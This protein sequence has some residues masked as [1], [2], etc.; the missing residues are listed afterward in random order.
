MGFLKFTTVAVYTLYCYQVCVYIY[1]GLYRTGTII[2]NPTSTPSIR[3]AVS[4]TP[5]PLFQSTVVLKPLQWP[6]KPRN[7]LHML[8]ECINFC[9]FVCLFVFCSPFC[10]RDQ[11]GGQEGL[12]RLQKPIM[13]LS[14]NY[15][16]LFCDGFAMSDQSI[17]WTKHVVLAQ[18]LV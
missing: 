9:L 12:L 7:D 1:F 4:A 5:S 14:V 11:T 18:L 17:F 10:Q 16:S 6:R 2:I 8:E 13:S 15:K 3:P